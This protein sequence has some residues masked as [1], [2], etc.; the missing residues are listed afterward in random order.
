MVNRYGVLEPYEQDEARKTPFEDL[1][2]VNSV[3]RDARFG[4]CMSGVKRS[5]TESALGARRM[6]GLNTFRTSPGMETPRGDFA[7]P[8]KHKGQLSLAFMLFVFCGDGRDRTA[9]LLI[10]NQ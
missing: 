1:F 10:A 2:F 6:E 3:V 8:E 5:D 9:N 7:R 4:A